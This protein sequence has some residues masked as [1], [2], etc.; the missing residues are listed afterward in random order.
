MREA[1]ESRR[2]FLDT[3]LGGS[4]AALGGAILFPIL[5]YLSPPRIPEAASTRV[6]AAKVAEIEKDRWKV[7]PFGA[8]AAILVAVS[9]GVYRAF[10]ATCTHLSCTVQFDDASKRIWCACHNGWYDLEGRNVA[11]P[12][13]KPLAPYGVQVE[14]DDVFVTRG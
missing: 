10:A 1:P 3:F 4:V 6:L 13:P 9:P 11:G 8:E 12:P 7:F 2:K 14:G 5:R